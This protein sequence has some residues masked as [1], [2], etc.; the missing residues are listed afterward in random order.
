M[1]LILQLFLLLQ[2]CDIFSTETICK[3]DETMTF[4]EICVKCKH[5]ICSD[6]SE[7]DPYEFL[8][9][10]SNCNKMWLQCLNGERGYH[11]KSD[12]CVPCTG[13]ICSKDPCQVPYQN[14]KN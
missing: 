11:R 12:S 1:I 14:K 6:Y 9:S 10:S 2:I 8:D 3:D 7:F 13:K 5:L 4:T